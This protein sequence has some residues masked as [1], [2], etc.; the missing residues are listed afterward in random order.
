MKEEQM[1]F[2]TFTKVFLLLAVLTFVLAAFGVTVGQVQMVPIGL[3]F[4]A[5][6]F[7]LP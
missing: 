3:A 6:A 2:L 1:T 5:A 4:F 7:L